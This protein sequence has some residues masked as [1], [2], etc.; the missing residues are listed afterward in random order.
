MA[1]EDTIL[2]GEGNDGPAGGAG[3]D[4]IIEPTT[5]ETAPETPPTAEPDKKPEPAPSARQPVQVEPDD[6]DKEFDAASEAI[7]KDEVLSDGQKRAEKLRLTVAREER[8]SRRQREQNEAEERKRNEEARSHGVT[9]Q[10]IDTAWDQAVDETMAK[11]GGK[12]DRGYAQ[13]LYDQKIAAAKTTH[14]APVAAKPKPTPTPVL[15]KGQV[16]PRGVGAVPNQPAP[17]DTRT[18][19]EKLIAGDLNKDLAAMYKELMEA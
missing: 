17:P 1:D 13:A 2:S 10:Q 6:I 4:S 7:E 9:R 18:V 3:D 19:E 11:K 15:G 8:T 5:T 14:A 16:L 12:F